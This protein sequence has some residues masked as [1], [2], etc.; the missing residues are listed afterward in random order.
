MARLTMI[1]YP[2]VAT[3]LAGTGVIAALGMG[4]M[5]LQPILLG[6]GVGAVV[7]LPVSW[8]VAKALE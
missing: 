1:L 7:A 4:Y 6:A 8:R 2:L 5:A 3:A